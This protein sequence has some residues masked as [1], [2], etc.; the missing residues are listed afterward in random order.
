[1]SLFL[2]AC[3]S[4]LCV[5]LFVCFIANNSILT[6]MPPVHFTSFAGSPSTAHDIVGVLS[7]SGYVFI[8]TFLVLMNAAAVTL[9]EHMRQ[10]ITF[11]KHRG[12]GFVSPSVFSVSL[13]RL[14]G[15]PMRVEAAT[16]PRGLFE[17][18]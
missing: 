1:M 14:S 4:D 13:S 12:A 7:V 11:Y 5:R 16:Y 15:Y 3:L 9:P 8:S 10:R 2:L 18:T 17:L 6:V